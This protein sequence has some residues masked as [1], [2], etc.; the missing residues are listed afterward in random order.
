MASLREA[1]PANV[2]RLARYLGLRIESL[3]DGQ[4]RRLIRWRTSPV[5]IT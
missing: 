2:R 5:R 3:S 1:K 4:V